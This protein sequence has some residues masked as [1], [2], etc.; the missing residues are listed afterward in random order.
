LA[1]AWGT[2]VT[3]KY[4]LWKFSMSLAGSK[5]NLK[6]MLCSLQLEPAPNCYCS[7]FWRSRYWTSNSAIPSLALQWRFIELESNINEFFA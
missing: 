7:W 2:F 5:M 4:G 6:K 3:Y 1:N